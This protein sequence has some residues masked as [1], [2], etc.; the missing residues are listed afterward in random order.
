MARP[1][2]NLYTDRWPT[3]PHF[4]Y[5]HEDRIAYL[6]VDCSSLKLSISLELLQRSVTQKSEI[7]MP[8]YQSFTAS[9]PFRPQS[10]QL[11]SA[12]KVK[13]YG[14]SKEHHSPAILHAPCIL[15]GGNHYG[16]L[17]NGRLSAR[18]D[19]NGASVSDDEST[20]CARPAL[21]S[22]GQF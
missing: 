8:E 3:S 4:I 10:R 9:L 5:A 13:R 22:L 18:C 1:F 17:K 20:P 14:L 19:D 16:R 2:P 15:D 7:F 12:W 21:C 6:L 11:P